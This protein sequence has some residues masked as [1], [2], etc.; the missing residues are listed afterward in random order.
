METRERHVS[1]TVVH[2][3][4][5]ALPDNGSVKRQ[6][7]NAPNQDV[8]SEPRVGLAPE[9]WLCTVCQNTFNK[10]TDKIL[11]CVVCLGHKCAK[12]LKLTKNQYEIT[13]RKDLTWTCQ[14]SCQDH[15][16]QALVNAAVTAKCV[17][18]AASHII[19]AVTDTISPT[20]I[21]D[22]MG[23]A[24][25]QP[26]ATTTEACEDVQ[27][28]PSVTWA[29]VVSRHEKRT[30]E[31]VKAAINEHTEEKNT[32]GVRERSIIIHRFI[33]SD[34]EKAE[35]CSE[36]DKT[37]FGQLSKNELGI[38][39]LTPEKIIRLGKRES[40][41]TRP[42]L[43]T[44]PTVL[45]KRKLMS[46]LHKLKNSAT[47]KNISV[48]HDLT[49]EERQKRSEIIEAAKRKKLEDPKIFQDFRI[50]GPP[51][52]LKVVWIKTQS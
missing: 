1:A 25:A 10:D 24:L 6:N 15:L 16:R 51:G 35:V 11:E 44:L 23:S 31:L 45:D 41:R 21:K 42:L 7:H 40:G 43:V 26:E 12:C 29:K 46:S 38:E 13:Q 19:K 48:T 8:N 27:E 9:Q 2:L 34:D 22:Q 33:E 52:N 32:S 3:T 30:K 14:D 37:S 49:K 28:A 47:F 17:A 4:G 39:N 20:I 36:H 18:A 5:S 50:R